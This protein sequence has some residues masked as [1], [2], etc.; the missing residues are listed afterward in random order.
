MTADLTALA[1][2]GLVHIIYFLFFSVRAN[3][4]LD[5]DYA[6]GPRDGTPSREPSNITAR[7]G[8]AY[9]NSAAMF[10]LFAG[11]VLLIAV[12]GQPSTITAA[13]SWAY[14]VLRVLY[15][16]AYMLGLTPWRSVFWIG[17][18]ICCAGLYI[19]ALV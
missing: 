19:A 2:A 9:D 12:S 6:L 14:V 1:L 3:R 17:C 13:L 8:R 18:L 11:A 7:L 4:E 16:P 15:T 10:G 5:L